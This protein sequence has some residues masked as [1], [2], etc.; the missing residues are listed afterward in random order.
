MPE[1]EASDTCYPRVLGFNYP[2]FSTVEV[3]YPSNSLILGVVLLIYCIREHVLLFLDVT[4][5]SRPTNDFP[6]V[7]L[8]C[9][10]G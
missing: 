9:E 2:Y 8:T 10:L 1:H 7:N 6:H 5:S 3:S 4:C